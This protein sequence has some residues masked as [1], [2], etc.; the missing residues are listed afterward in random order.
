MLEELLGAN[1]AILKALEMYDAIASGKEV[2]QIGGLVR[3]SA[4]LC[5]HGTYP[6]TRAG[7]LRNNVSLTPRHTGRQLKS[8]QYHRPLTRLCWRLSSKLSQTCLL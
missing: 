8:P 6:K 4:M 1:E 7:A 2:Q 3:H 5:L